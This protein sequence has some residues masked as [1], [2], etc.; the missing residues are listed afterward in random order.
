MKIV[1]LQNTI[2]AGKRL[3]AGETTEVS[4]A[5]ANHLALLDLAHIVDAPTKEPEVKKPVRRRRATK[6]VPT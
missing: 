6:A 3:L 1:L 4:E 5:F 2:L